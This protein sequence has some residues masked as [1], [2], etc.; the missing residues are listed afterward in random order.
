M[1][2]NEIQTLS[3]WGSRPQSIHLSSVTPIHSGVQ[4]RNQ[5]VTVETYSHLPPDPGITGPHLSPQ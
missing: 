2:L 4:A 5:E 3:K 1:D